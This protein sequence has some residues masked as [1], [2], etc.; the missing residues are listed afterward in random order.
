[1]IVELVER[2]PRHDSAGRARPLAILGFRTFPG[3]WRNGRAAPIF[4]GGAEGLTKER[5]LQREFADW[6]VG[7]DAD[8][9]V[10]AVELRGP[11]RL[12][13]YLDRPAGVDLALC[14]RVTGVLREY[15]DRYGSRCRPRGSSVRSASRRTSPARSGRNVA[16]GVS[17]IEGRRRF[18]GRGGRGGGPTRSR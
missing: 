15:L 10:L 14:E 4:Q 5:T 9:E 6:K 7:A 11:E 1:M 17:E 3:C 8:V 12:T 2:R 13:V 16:Y 18:Q